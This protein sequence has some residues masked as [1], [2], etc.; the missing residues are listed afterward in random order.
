MTTIKKFTVFVGGTEV[1]DYY[2]ELPEATRIAMDY[3]RQGYNDVSIVS[4]D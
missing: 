3:K 1:N 2:L 4:I